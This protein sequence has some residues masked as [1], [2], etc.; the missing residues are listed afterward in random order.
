MLGAASRE[1]RVHIGLG[2]AENLREWRA[3]APIW[4]A[5]QRSARPTG[6][7]RIE[8]QTCRSRS[9][10]RWSCR[11]APGLRAGRGLKPG[12]WF[13]RYITPPASRGAPGLRAGRGLKRCGRSDRSRCRVW[14]AR[15]TGRARIE[16]GWWSSTCRTRRSGAP[17]LRAGRGLKLDRVAGQPRQPRGAPGLRAGRG[18]KRLHRHAGVARHPGAPGLRAGR[19]LKRG[20]QL[21]LRYGLRG[22]PGLRAGRGLKPREQHVDVGVDRRERPAYG[23]G[24]D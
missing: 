21:S 7:A 11:G 5:T 15:P 14:S 23:P 13:D 16:T 24:E 20:R 8:T 6:R 19:G 4:W 22:A 12:S 9:S 10:C 3:R 2:I 17:G 1:R 18:L